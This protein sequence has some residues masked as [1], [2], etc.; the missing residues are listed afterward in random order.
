MLYNPEK[1]RRRTIRLQDYDYSQAGAYFITICTKNRECLFG[2]IVDSEMC[3]NEWGE[4]VAVFWNE[5]PRH[6]RNVELDA[7][8]VMPNHVHGVLIIIDNGRGTACRAP[9]VE[10]FGKPVANSLP[11]IIR[12]FKSAT[13]KRINEIHATHGIPIWQ[14]NYLPHEI[15]KKN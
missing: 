7:F 3:L 5:V 8:I 4:I 6:F 2:E 9:T 1:H 11:T 10:R 15:K 12:S 14:R 13:T